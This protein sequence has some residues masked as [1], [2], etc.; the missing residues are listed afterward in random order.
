[1]NNHRATNNFICRI[2]LEIMD[3][4]TNRINNL[5]LL[6][7][8][9]VGKSLML[10]YWVVRQNRTTR[11]LNFKKNRIRLIDIRTYDLNRKFKILHMQSLNSSFM[12]V[13]NAVFVRYVGNKMW[14]QLT[15]TSRP[16]S[17]HSLTSIRS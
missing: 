17:R 16:F 15:N 5:K 13:T 12:R 4:L 8:M 14:I 1:M 7:V 9:L 6:P 10:S 3:K 11:G 2:Q